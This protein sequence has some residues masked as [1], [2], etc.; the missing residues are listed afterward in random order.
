MALKARSFFRERAILERL[1]T[2]DSY[3]G[4]T[5]AEPL[6]IR[7]RLLAESEMIRT[8]DG[9]EIVTAGRISTM[10][11]L[12]EGDR[13]THAYGLTGRIVRVRRNHGTDGRFS[14]YVG[15]VGGGT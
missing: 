11:P 12:A 7:V 10:T 13:I 14:H 8:G 6:T 4:D 1:V 9:R 15:D 5:F 2:A 3:S